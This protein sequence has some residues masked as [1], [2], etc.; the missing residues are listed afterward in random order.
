M[1]ALIGPGDAQPL[2]GDPAAVLVARGL[3]GACDRAGL[4][5]V[6]TGQSDGLL[7]DGRVFFR[8][9]SDPSVRGPSTSA[10]TSC[11]WR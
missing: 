8:T 2:L 1:I 7:V 3:I 9:L 4:S 5:L 10:W 6:L 11:C